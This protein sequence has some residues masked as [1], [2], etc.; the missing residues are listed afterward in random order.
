MKRRSGEGCAQFVV[1]DRR[2]RMAIEPRIPHHAG[3]EH[4]GF[5]PTEETEWGGGGI[6]LPIM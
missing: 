3:T 5:S 2:S 1:R 6:A 4:V